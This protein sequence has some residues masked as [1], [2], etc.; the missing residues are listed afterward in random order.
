MSAALA[1]AA[2]LLA[3]Q[4]AVP[5]AQAAES[6]WSKATLLYD[7]ER[8]PEAQPVFERFI[9]V[10]KNPAPA[11]AFLALCEYEN[12]QY[13][14][15]IAH[16]REWAKRGSPGVRQL[17]ASAVF[18]WALLL[19]R[20]GQF[21]QALHLLEGGVKSGEESPAIAEALGLASLR[22]RH[23]PEDY[24]PARR[25]LVYQAGKVALYTALRR[26]TPA[27]YE[28]QT[29]LQR[30]G[31]EPG[32]H[33][34]LG[35]RHLQDH[36]DDLAAAEFRQELEISPGHVPALLQ[37]A[38]H[39]LGKF[40]PSAAVPFAEHAVKLAPGLF[41]A[42]HTLGQALLEV[43]RFPESIA[44]LERARTLAPENPYVR[45]ALSKAYAG[46]GRDLD[47]SRE[48]AL[49]AELKEKEHR[50]RAREAGRK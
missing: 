12:R 17:I 11:Y 42:H 1:L 20:E 32:V 37:M 21:E 43:K 2:V 40:D 8:F 30:Y 45:L 44:E 4:A 34:L 50:L 23:L 9:A 7:Q 48:R 47:A 13:E 14:R 19:T 5:R 10:S 38:I 36:N 46:V 29:L 3:T 24:P 26:Q 16:F 18:H 27:G 6:L 28:S 22:M 39:H 31:R 41:A 49:F 25:E 35:T 33:Y 15:S